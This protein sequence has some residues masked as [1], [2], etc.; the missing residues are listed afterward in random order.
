MNFNQ[1]WKM[2]F[3]FYYIYILY[4]YTSEFLYFKL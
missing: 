1:T 4:I 3:A 2:K